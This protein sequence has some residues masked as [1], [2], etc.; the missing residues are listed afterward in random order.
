M[1]AKDIKCTGCGVTAQDLIDRGEYEDM[2]EVMMDGTYGNRKFVCTTCYC[3]LIP[4]GY[5]VGGP[6]VIQQ[7][8]SIFCRKKAKRKK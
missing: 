1:D 8:A 7:R 6:E 2:Q 3:V 5:D 4:L